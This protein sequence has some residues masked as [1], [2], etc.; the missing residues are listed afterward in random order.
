MLLP[1]TADVAVIPLVAVA[2]PEGLKLGVRGYVMHTRAQTNTSALVMPFAHHSLH[3][4][5]SILT[6]CVSKKATKA[7]ISAPAVII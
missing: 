7:M 4:G 5:T 1:I 2:E 3:Y 6:F